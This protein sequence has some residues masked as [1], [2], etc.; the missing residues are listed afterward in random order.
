MPAPYAA[1]VDFDLWPTNKV[2][3]LTEFR[4][5]SGLLPEDIENVNFKRVSLVKFWEICLS[6]QPITT[7]AKGIL[8]QDHTDLAF[9]HLTVGS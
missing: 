3:P 7:C 5:V 8:M 9:T 1:S 2:G 6:P 4:A